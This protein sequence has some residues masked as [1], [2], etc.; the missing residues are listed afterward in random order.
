MLKLYHPVAQ[1]VIAFELPLRWMES[2]LTGVPIKR[3][4]LNT[5]G[6]VSCACAKRKEQ[7]ESTANRQPY[8]KSNKEASGKTF[9]L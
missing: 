7:I 3:K 4:T 1:N 8:F 2:N 6:N 5:Q 9:T